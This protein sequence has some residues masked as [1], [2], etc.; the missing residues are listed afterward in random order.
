MRSIYLKF[1]HIFSVFSSIT[2]ASN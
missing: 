2:L 1:H